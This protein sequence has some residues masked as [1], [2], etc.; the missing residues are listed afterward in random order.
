M[1]CYTVSRSDT[2]SRG[3]R[4]RN[5]WGY[6]WLDGGC[7]IKCQTNAETDIPPPRG[8]MPWCERLLIL[9]ATLRLIELVL[10]EADLAL[11]ES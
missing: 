8:D 5:H 11:S 9:S 6:T 7:N 10:G 2:M 1:M 4:D 3:V